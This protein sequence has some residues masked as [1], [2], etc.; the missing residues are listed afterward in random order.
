MTNPLVYNNCGNQDFSQQPGHG[1]V[2]IPQLYPVGIIRGDFGRPL[3][4][5]YLSTSQNVHMLG[6]IPGRRDPI[7]LGTMGRP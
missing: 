7:Q 2:E 4:M 6:I 5:C 1:V 3:Q